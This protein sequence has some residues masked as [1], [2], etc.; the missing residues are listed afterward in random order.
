MSELLF[1]VVVCT[2][3]RSGLLKGSIE[4][5]FAQTLDP[6]LFEIIVIDNQSTDDTAEIVR[7]TGGDRVRYFVEPQLGLSPARNRGWRE[8]RGRWVG[9]LDDDAKAAPDWLVVAQSIA[10]GRAPELFGGPFLPFYDSPRPAWFKDA[11]G[12]REIA[13]E[14]RDLTGIETLSGSNIFVLREL[15]ASS[16]GFSSEFGMT[17]G[18]VA[19]GEETDLQLR[20]KRERPGIKIFYDPALIVYHLVRAGKMSI[21]WQFKQVAAG[22]RDAARILHPLQPEKSSARMAFDLIRAAAKTTFLFAATPLRDRRRY[23]Y[24]HN[25]MIESVFVPLRRVFMYYH[26]LKRRKNL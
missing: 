23:P 14:A 11:Y 19:Y 17:G 22:A 7:R 8:A 1:S 6:A 4:S 3:N 13:P 25:Y 24:A 9:Y 21:G 15:F 16:G 5:L 20:L 26:T 2:R 10:T 12:S 18:R